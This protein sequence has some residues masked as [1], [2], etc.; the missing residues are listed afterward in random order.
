MWWQSRQVEPRRN[1]C[2]R[3]AGGSLPQL[4]AERLFAAY[5]VVNAEELL[6]L[7]DNF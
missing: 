6:L 5:A 3:Q 2:G 4:S 1:I 7:L